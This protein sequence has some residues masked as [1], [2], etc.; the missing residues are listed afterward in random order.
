MAST[1]RPAAHDRAGGQGSLRRR[2]PRLWRLHA[3][4][5]RQGDAYAYSK[6]CHPGAIVRRWTHDR[7]LEA[8]RDWRARYGRLPSSYDWSRTHAT[9]RGGEVAGNKLAVGQQ[10]GLAA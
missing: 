2:V 8:M 6:V 1:R 4:A 10:L 9:R 3:A 7:V 5:Q